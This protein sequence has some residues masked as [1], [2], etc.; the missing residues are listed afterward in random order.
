MSEIP[1]ARDF[2]VSGVITLRPEMT[3]YEAID[4]LLK[5]KI[6]G[7]PVVDAEGRIIGV[8]SEKDC[9]KIFANVVYHQLVFGRV[10]EYMSKVVVT[11]S[12]DDD[13]FQLAGVFMKHV[14]RRLPIVENGKLVGQVSRRD[15]LDASRKMW[16]GSGV[17]KPWTDSK[18]LTEEM[19][20]VISDGLPPPHTS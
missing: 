5:H 17:K 14:F 10:G 9:L 3:I 6:S 13:L 19:K 16:E 18:Y 1:V 11:A 4:T 20:S 2:M 8:L 12:P 7:A 15:V